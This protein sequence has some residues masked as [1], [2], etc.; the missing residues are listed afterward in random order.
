MRLLFLLF[1]SVARIALCEDAAEIRQQIERLNV[2]GRALM[3]AAHPDDEQTAILAYLSKGRKVRTA[4]LSATR[5]EGGQN[6]IGS[7][8]GVLLGVVRTQ[9][10]LA[11]R[12]IDGA[13]QYFTRA[14][15][16]GYTKT[17][18]ETLQ[19]WGGDAV[20]RD[21]VLMIRTYRPDV[22][23]LRFS[24]TPRDGH[25]QHQASAVLGRKAY[26]AAADSTQ[27]PDLGPA[28]KPR[29][30]V[31]IS[32]RFDRERG[33]EVNEPADF[34]IPIG[35][36]NALLGKSYTE[37]A[38]LSRS[39]HESQAM[40][41]A[42]QRGAASLSFKLLE[43]EP[44]K[45]DVFDGID[46]TWDRFQGGSA[47][48][49]IIDRVLREY[50]AKAPAKSVPALLDARRSIRAINDPWATYKLKQIDE[51]IAMAS[52]IRADFLSSGENA[53]P[54][55][56]TSVTFSVINRS[57]V[58]WTLVKAAGGSVN[59]GASSPLANNQTLTRKVDW[60]IPATQPF[61]QPFWL[62]TPPQGDLYSI[63]DK[64]LINRAD[65][66]PALTARFELE[67]GGEMIS[68]DRPLT[69]RYVDPVRGE[70]HRS[71]VVLPPVSVS[72][73]APVAIFSDNTLRKLT[74]QV[75]ST[76]S[77]VSGTLRINAGAGWKVN[78]ES[79][80][81]S[82]A[83][84]N[85]RQDIEFEITPP[86]KTSSTFLVAEAEVNGKRYGDT[87]RVLPYTHI[88]AQTVLTP[89]RIRAERIE[90]TNLSR[91][92]GYVEGAGDVVPDALRQIGC[93]VTMLTADDL[94][95]GD[96]S[97]FDAI[98]TGVRAYL[99]RP[100]LRAN[101]SRLFDYVKQ[102]GTMVVQYN[103]AFPGPGN[104]NP[105]LL[106]NLGPYPIKLGSKRVSVETAEVGFPDPSHPLLNVPNKI[107]QADF[108]GWIQER[109][110]YFA[111]QWAPEYQP[112]W[113]SHDPGEPA[114]G[115]GELYAR[116]G[117]GVYIYTGYSWFR[118]L[119]AG[120]PGAFRIFANMLSAG[121]AAK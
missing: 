77:A 63:S 66:L 103:V 31:R 79:A 8:Q 42:E 71:F 72:L 70:V 104:R 30:M 36:Y 101:Q 29:R 67:T 97:R 105:E 118:Q 76:F 55:A 35:D 21:M 75:T 46:T 90:L 87:V 117:K 4:Y 24:G 53:V 85:G 26:D 15:D 121:R 88:P 58:P 86:A 98:V 110:L 22:V 54:G 62:K 84:R 49:S 61:S 40:G 120:V 114:S 57:D 111:E 68:L 50:D 102:G 18:E 5:G 113:T 3:I 17:L 11:A 34:Q 109:G 14:I 96:L 91:N 56:T 80:P 23:I 32:S 12:R 69:Y 47:V 45:G 82:I 13:E 44:G 2:V 119:P 73:T 94:A 37:I 81:F 39:Q 89:A 59:A 116:Y 65:A 19:H 92:V 107:T 106:A 108:D 28:W 7:E 9:E 6:L 25:G 16:F 115:G 100:D 33:A 52:G 99:V 43:G 1:L 74:L 60:Q 48:S 20:L 27:F 41:A 93:S 51:I 83:A 10:L 95:R 64:D 38:G 112:V 78:P